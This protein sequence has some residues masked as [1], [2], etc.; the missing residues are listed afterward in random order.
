MPG[1]ARRGNQPNPAA[2][3]SES[4][5]DEDSSSSED[6]DSDDDHHPKAHIKA[7]GGA[8]PV[9]QPGATNLNQMWRKQ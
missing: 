7:R 1:Q 8:A 3:S 9:G 4:D 6:S 2:D 5:D